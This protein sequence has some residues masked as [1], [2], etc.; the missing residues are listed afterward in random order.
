MLA[1]D[2]L[3]TQMLAV[4]VGAKAAAYASDAMPGQRTRF[5]GRHLG[6]RR[7]TP[8]SHGNSAT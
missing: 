5:L 7:N 6:L 1:Y 4:Q 3:L 2:H 8:M